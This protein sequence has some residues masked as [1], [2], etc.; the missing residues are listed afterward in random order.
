MRPISNFKSNFKPTYFPKN[1]SC[2]SVGFICNPT[3]LSSVLLK[4][5]NAYDKYQG[6]S[7]LLKSHGQRMFSPK[8]VARNRMRQIDGWTNRLFPVSFK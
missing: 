8:T 7:K 6:R 2:V 3:F 1:N 4:F 5:T